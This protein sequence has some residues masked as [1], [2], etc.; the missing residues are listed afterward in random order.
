ML[1]GESVLVYLCVV[2]V[3]ETLWV[4]DMVEPRRMR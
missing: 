2:E 3:F 1:R 4:C